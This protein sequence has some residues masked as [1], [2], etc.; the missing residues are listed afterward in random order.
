[1]L[2]ARVR[3]A[4]RRHGLLAR[5]DAVVVAVSGGPDS[6]ALLH[7][8]AIL[9]RKEAWKLHAAHLHHG[10]RGAEADADEDLV[11]ALAA[12]ERVGVTV[13]RLEPA[14]LAGAALEARARSARYAF[15][16]DV[17][18]SFGA[19]RIATGHTRDDQ[20]ETVLLRLLRGS[21][22]RGL[23]G[24]Q[25]RRADGVIRPLILA[26]RAEVLRF[27]DR[28]RLPSRE[29]SSNRDPRHLR[30]RVRHELLPLLR[31]LAPGIDARLAAIADH[32]RADSAYLDRE[33]EAAARALGAG[34]GE[35]DAARVRALPEAIRVRVIE[36]MLR[37]K[38]AP[39][40]RLGAAI[41]A[42]EEGLTRRRA[43]AGRILAIALRAGLLAEIDGGTLRICRAK[44][45][46]RKRS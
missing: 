6:V 46:T 40:D 29:D 8:L 23:G 10:L 14:R 24:I 21:G 33:G 42:L 2:L 38:G 41:A 3:Q 18:R 9:A 37:A 28:A 25:P 36:A 17:A 45:A 11:R 43:G 15:L 26:S 5:G 32:L 1:M 19:A 44:G 31:A 7:A 20:A 13:G 12:R 4:I 39:E 34:E 22:A 35:A 16:A 27:L 30:N